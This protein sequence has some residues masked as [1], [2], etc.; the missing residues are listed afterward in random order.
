M[1]VFITCNHCILLLR[2]LGQRSGELAAQEVVT[3]F[4]LTGAARLTP[5]SPAVVVAQ[6]LTK[7]RK[8]GEWFCEV[9]KLSHALFGHNK[10]SG[11]P[12]LRICKAAP[13]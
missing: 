6:P 4:K 3:L 1:L 13:D 9:I 8:V 12:Q 11:A 2:V 7:V 5:A 10:S